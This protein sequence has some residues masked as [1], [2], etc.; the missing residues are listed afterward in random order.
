MYFISVGRDKSLILRCSD[1]VGRNKVSITTG[2]KRVCATCFNQCNESKIFLPVK[3]KTQQCLSCLVIPAQYFMVL[4]KLLQV[5]YCVAVSVLLSVFGILCVTSIGDDY[6]YNIKKCHPPSVERC[7]SF[8]LTFLLIDL[9]LCLQTAIPDNFHYLTV[10]E[11]L[12]LLLDS[13]W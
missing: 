7:C 8:S 12:P 6:F 9:I 3:R 1:Y 4:W 11:K 5:S 10:S 13:Y 2:A